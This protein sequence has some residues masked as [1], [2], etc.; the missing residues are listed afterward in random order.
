MNNKK[1]STSFSYKKKK[2][3]SEKDNKNKYG[4]TREQCKLCLVYRNRKVFKI[5]TAKTVD[6]L[7]RKILIY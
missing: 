7:M 6:F 4:S 2:Q 1:K 3:E 5:M